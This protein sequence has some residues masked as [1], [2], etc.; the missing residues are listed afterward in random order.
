MPCLACR[1]PGYPLCADC[2]R[3]LHPASR[4]A[5]GEGVYAMGVWSHAGTGRL[6][7]QRLKYEGLAAIVTL[8]VRQLPDRP[9]GVGAVVPIPRVL[10]RR[11]DHGV[12]PAAVFARAVA[13]AWQVPYVEALAAPVWAPRRAGRR[14]R[15]APPRFR[16]I[17][18][19]PAGAVVVDDV[20]T[21]GRTVREAAHLA[22]ADRALAMTVVRSPNPPGAGPTAIRWAE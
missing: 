11:L 17:R 13:E 22:G 4:R 3:R 2:R 15:A 9:S 19:V 6:L 14:L 8:A 12:D 20:I 5:L 18:P 1:R 16:C 21:S 7:V 10:V